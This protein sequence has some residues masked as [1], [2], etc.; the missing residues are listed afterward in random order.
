MS[1]PLWTFG[2]VREALGGRL[3][4]EPPEG[5]SGVS[6]DSREIAGGELFFAIRGVRTDGHA[7]AARALKAGAALAVVARPDEDMRRA[8]PLLVVPDTLAAL[9]ALGRA[10]RARTAGRVVGV[11]G[12]VGKT[13]TKDM[14]ALA[15]SAVGRT[16]AAR[17]SFNNQWGVPLTLARLPRDAQYAVI[18]MG[19]NAPG[20]IAALAEMARP[21][22]AVVTQIAESHIGAFGDLAGI[23]RAK[24]EIFS[25]LAPGGVAVLNRDMPHFGILADAAAAAGAGEI[26]TFGSHEAADVRLAR[27][28]S[29]ETGVCV[30]ATARG[31]ALA[32]RVGMPGRHAAENSLAVIGAALA[33]GLDLTAVIH[34]LA[35]MRPPKGRGGRFRLAGPGGEI[36]LID[37]SYNANPASVRAA[38]ASLAE[39][40]PGEGGRRI[41]V[42]GDML[43]L[44]AAGP[45]LHAA[46]AK[47]VEE[48]GVDALYVC[49]PLMKHLW[50]A[51]PARLRAA[52][53]ETSGELPAI[54]KRDLR[55]GDVVMIKG[56]LGS[57]MGPVV[58]AL[59]GMFEPS[60]N[61]A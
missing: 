5:F 26:I 57:R 27:A 1:A 54:L 22:V 17:A 21:H 12:S 18:E 43:E 51:A 7:Y 31:R 60:G 48:A 6:F 30:D 19:M 33:L 14:M 24:A 35:A 15:F 9:Q 47:D 44:G 10:A 40:A 39:T 49:G 55:G 25:G 58:E 41:A 23:A 59:I 56:S 20:E 3:I 37:E 8:G 34:A 53:T 36:L 28:V 13:T 42:L 50:E 4:G 32:W 29:G 52:R 38:L 61:E 16:H 2:E 46:L 11:T 45:A